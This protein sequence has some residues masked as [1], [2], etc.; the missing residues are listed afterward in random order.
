MKGSSIR[1]TAQV[2]DIL[3]RGFLEHRKKLEAI[4]IGI[5]SPYNLLEEKLKSALT[6]LIGDLK[7][8]VDYEMLGKIINHNSLNGWTMTADI[9]TDL[10]FDEKNLLLSS[11]QL[12]IQFETY[13]EK[14]EYRELRRLKDS[15]LNNENSKWSN[16]LEISFDLYHTD[17]YKI[18]IPALIAIVEG[19]MSEVVDSEKF[20]KYLFRDFKTQIDEKDKFLAYA[21]YS[22]YTFLTE[23]LF[24]KHSFVDA[25]TEIINRNWV[26]HGRDDP[27][28][29][30]KIDVL[31]L[32]NTIGS[33]RFLKEM[34]S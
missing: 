21:S 14:D 18:S 13:Y 28:E 30:T 16:L 6:D 10:Y 24:K 23:A 27:D 7:F 9:S 15:L 26:L 1:G 22:M 32:F 29:W 25:R 8:P 4:K 19:E 20:G 31:R 2:K 11:N 5:K 17:K 3:E 34:R 12:D 33:I